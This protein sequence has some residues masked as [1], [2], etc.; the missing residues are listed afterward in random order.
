MLSI[1]VGVR[2]S[3]NSVAFNFSSLKS[4]E[5]KY[6]QNFGNFVNFQ[7]KYFPLPLL[8]QSNL[9]ILRL[10]KFQGLPILRLQKLLYYSLSNRFEVA[11][12]VRPLSLLPLH[13]PTVIS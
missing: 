6:F 8:I 2:N 3:F 11:E 10:L 13:S 12:D 5:S 1:I 7:I 9:S 4:N